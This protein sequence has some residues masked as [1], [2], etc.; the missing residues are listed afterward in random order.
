MEK[1]FSKNRMILLARNIWIQNKSK[2]L[3]LALLI[4]AI[5]TFIGLVSSANEDYNLL[6]LPLKIIVIVLAGTT[7]KKLAIPSQAVSYF[8]IPV[9]TAEKTIVAILFLQLYY[10]IGI[11]ILSFVG[12]YIGQIIHNLILFIPFFKQLFIEIE[13]TTPHFTLS[14]ISYSDIGTSLL[15]LTLYVSIFLFGS[16]YFRKNAIIKTLLSVGGFIFAIMIINI[17]ILG[18]VNINHPYNHTS[19]NL[20]NLSVETNIIS[21]T[22]KVLAILFF[23]FITYLRLK[24]TEA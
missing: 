16:I 4:V 6:N 11:G 21:Y 2:D 3:H 12:F 9:S 23:W 18:I 5:M 13:S 8:M 1:I 24:E 10:I 22:L 14:S 7:F 19:F 17:I 15:N 20:V